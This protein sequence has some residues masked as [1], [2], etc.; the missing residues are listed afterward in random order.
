MKTQNTV[1]A[2]S[3][4]FAFAASHG[5]WAAQKDWEYHED[6]WGQV[7]S[8]GK[9]PISNDSSS[10]WGPWSEFIEPAAGPVVPF[11]AETEGDKYRP[12]YN[13]LTPPPSVTPGTPPVEPPFPPAVDTCPPGVACGYAIYKNFSSGG[14][15]GGYG[16]DNSCGQYGRCGDPGSGNNGGYNGYYPATFTANATFGDPGPWGP[17]GMFGQKGSLDG[18][19]GLAKLNGSDPNPL[20]T[21]SG[22]LSGHYY[23][24]NSSWSW[25]FGPPS[26]NASR[27]DSSGGANIDGK[28]TSA[29]DSQTANGAFKI[30]AYMN[31]K[32]WSECWSGC[33]QSSE[34]VTGYYIAGY[35]TAAAYMDTLRAG[36]VNAQYTGKEILGGGGV[37]ID[38]QFGPATWNGTW[39]GPG[40]TAAGTVT[41]ANIQSTSVGGNA[42]SGQV[43]G[44]FYGSQAQGLAGVSDVNLNNGTRHVDLFATQKVTP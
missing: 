23:L 12:Y 26:G 25:L 36:N 17:W 8:Y 5:A 1:I 3:L 16:Y 44:T 32:G 31:G 20:F 27:N 18:N 43:Q 39:S 38:V 14:G 19:F 24:P 30:Y 6:N 35:P 41:N 13:P 21:A 15:Q 9:T 4:A 29:A 2:L 34:G 11:L 42:A 40:F 33:G 22:D 7:I 28:L 10:E 37:L